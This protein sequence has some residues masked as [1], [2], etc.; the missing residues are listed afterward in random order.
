MNNFPYTPFLFANGVDCV[1]TDWGGNMRCC[2][3]G[4]EHRRREW[5]KADRRDEAHA[6]R[7]LCWSGI[8]FIGNG[9]QHLVRTF[10]QRFDPS[11]AV[12][13]TTL[14]AAGFRAESLTFLTAEHLLVQ[15]MKIT[16][17]PDRNSESMLEF[18]LS[19]PEGGSD[20]EE[21]AL[22]DHRLLMRSGK[23][24]CFIAAGHAEVSGAVCSEI[25][26]LTYRGGR[27]ELKGLAK[28]SEFT[29]YTCAVD[30]KDGPNALENAFLSI[31]SGYPSILRRH[32]TFWKK[33]RAESTFQPPEEFAALYEFSRWRVRSCLHP[34]TGGL[35]TG[36]LPELWQGKIFW[37]S[38][39]M[40][41][42]L[43]EAGHVA[44]GVSAARFWLNTLEK[45]RENAAFL[46]F[47]GARY[48]WCT[49]QTGYCR[50]LKLIREFHN[51]P[52]AVLSMWNACEF[53]CDSRLAESLFPAM[54]DAMRFMLDSVVEESG[55]EAVI[56][57]CQGVD[58]STRKQSLND[59]WTCAATIAGL[60]A[61]LEAAV[62][63]DKT[64]PPEF[65]EI[66]RKLWIGLLNNRNRDGVLESSRNSGRTNFGCMVN[67][68][69]EDFPI[70]PTLDEIWRLRGKFNS[71]ARVGFFHQDAIDVPWFSA[72][73][74]A[75]NA[76]DG[77]KRR[78]VI[79]LRNC[80]RWHD[81]FGGLP[82]QVRPDGTLYKTNMGT[83]HAAFMMALHRI[84]DVSPRSRQGR[85]HSGKTSAI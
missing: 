15:R 42:A 84:H 33:F 76:L 81:S 14:E 11:R 3:K 59:T 17:V 71:P 34:E 29:L 7:P 54:L 62:L 13:H 8:L 58:E 4:L 19:A 60:R 1:P 79:Y 16:A 66:E 26:R 5:Y 39:F 80:L 36:L 40:E 64:L 68:I 50:E 35:P 28:G 31:K 63:L 75:A 83:A 53:S 51:N 22:E 43:L 46:G 73:A 77:N 65:A 57:H 37:D 30:E 25:G 27:L 69:L 20:G 32:E 67:L 55:E 47:R 44:E 45:A 52:M 74:A 6:L 78:A 85:A 48:G 21:F 49:D 82:E 70:T 9:E 41:R 56:G 2:D 10:K 12:L 23:T 38:W 61:L 24:V 18:V 72:W